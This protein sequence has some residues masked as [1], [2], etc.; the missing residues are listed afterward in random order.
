VYVATATCQGTIEVGVTQDTGK[1][2]TTHTVTED[3]TTN[4]FS[5]VPVAVDEEG[6]VYVS[7]VG[8]AGQLYY[9]FSED[10]SEGFSQPRQ[11]EPSPLS[12][13]AL[14]TA[15]ALDPGRVAIGYLATPDGNQS[16]PDEVPDDAEWTLHATVLADADTEDPST[17]TARAGPSDAVMHEGPCSFDGGRCGAVKDYIDVDRNAK[18]R[19]YVT[20]VLSNGEGV[21]GVQTGGPWLVNGN[22]STGGTR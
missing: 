12:S 16:Y 15:T 11:I 20:G 2:W 1:H 19:I 14:P 22:G 3:V 10:P 5:P 21:L 7:W 9:A 13:T 8:E 6:T 18:G 4:N 17:A